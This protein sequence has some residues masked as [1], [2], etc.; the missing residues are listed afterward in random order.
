MEIL[1]AIGVIEDIV[2][3]GEISY[4]DLMSLDHLADRISERFVEDEP[5]RSAGL[6]WKPMRTKV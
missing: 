2:M 4:R 6:G 3:S 5:D 1:K